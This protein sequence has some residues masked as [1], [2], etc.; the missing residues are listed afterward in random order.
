MNRRLPL[1]C[2]GTRPAAIYCATPSTMAVLPTPGSPIR[3]GLFLC[4]LDRICS[5]VSISCCRPTIIS[6]LS[7]RS[8]IST[9]NWSSRRKFCMVSSFLSR[10]ASHRAGSSA[11]VEICEARSRRTAP[12]LSRQSIASRSRSG[13]TGCTAAAAAITLCASSENPC[14]RRS[15]RCPGRDPRDELPAP[16]LRHEPQKHGLRL[17]ALPYHQAARAAFGRPQEPQQKMLRSHISVSQRTGDCPCLPE[18]LL[19]QRIKVIFPQAA[20]PPFPK[21][22]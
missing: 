8:T 18:H 5:T 22:S 15:R 16:I 7:A 3:A 9:P 2:S 1:S 6:V 4:F 17:R 10:I 21:N 20:P 12:Q 13:Q 11:P 14:G 19:R